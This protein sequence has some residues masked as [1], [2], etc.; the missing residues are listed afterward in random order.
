M[1]R[2]LT[3][4]TDRVALRGSGIARDRLT[5]GHPMRVAA[6]VADLLRAPGGARDRQL[7]HGA[8]VTLIEERDP[9]AKSVEDQRAELAATPA[10]IGRNR[11][12]RCAARPGPAPGPPAGGTTIP[13]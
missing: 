9:G 12:S 4:A 2:R 3:P 5:E 1:D 13:A 7:L 8:D 11:C 10:E 6:P